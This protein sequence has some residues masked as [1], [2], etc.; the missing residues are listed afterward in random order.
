MRSSTRANAIRIFDTNEQGN[1]MARASRIPKGFRPPAQGCEER[2]TLGHR[3]QSSQPQRGCVPRGAKAATPLGLL[4]GDAG[5]QGSSFLATLGSD[6]E[7]RWDSDGEY[8]KGIAA[9]LHFS[10][11]GNVPGRRRKVVRGFRPYRAA[12]G[13]KPQTTFAQP[14]PAAFTQNDSVQIVSA[15]LE[16]FGTPLPP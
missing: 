4:H 15:G 3:G 14:R 2:A 10:P 1:R 6:T 13:L 9:S 5:S 16:P 8:P 12:G 7:S 11:P